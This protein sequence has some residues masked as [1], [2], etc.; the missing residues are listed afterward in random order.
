MLWHKTAKNG[1]D[2]FYIFLT[3]KTSL[4]ADREDWGEGGGK[5]I[6]PSRDPLAPVN[7]ACR[8]P[9]APVNSSTKDSPNPSKLTNAY[10][11]QPGISRTHLGSTRDALGT[12]SATFSFIPQESQ[13]P[14]PKGTRPP[15]ELIE[16][17]SPSDSITHTGAIQISRF[18]PPNL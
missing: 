8:D 7:N 6:N 9:L 18:H 10:Q 13:G 2:Y 12:R 15:G 4:K 1:H 3:D 11:D 5:L 14:T 17:Q 16:L